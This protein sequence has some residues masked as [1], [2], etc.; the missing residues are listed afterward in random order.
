MGKRISHQIKK[1]EKQWHFEKSPNKIKVGPKEARFITHGGGQRFFY[2]PIAVIRSLRR[3]LY[4]EGIVM[5]EKQLRKCVWLMELKALTLP[6]GD[7][8]KVVTNK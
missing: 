4:R 3:A 7:I 2:M 1:T 8:Y 5:T 6:N